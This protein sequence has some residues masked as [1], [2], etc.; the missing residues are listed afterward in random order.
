MMTNA[1]AALIAAASQVTPN[2]T[3]RVVINAPNGRFSADIQEAVR[4]LATEYKQ[5]LDEQDEKNRAA[6]T[7]SQ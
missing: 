3:G 7:S 6:L 2:S 4:L 1:Q 5:W